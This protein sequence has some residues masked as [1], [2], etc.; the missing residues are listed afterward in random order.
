[1]QKYDKLSEN[2]EIMTNT[3][4]I[5]QIS[6]FFSL[7]R[8]FTLVNSNPFWINGGIPWEQ[9]QDKPAEDL[10]SF[11]GFNQPGHLKCGR[12]FMLA[13]ILPFRLQTIIVLNGSL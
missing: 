3:S 5:T 10:V 2:S 13:L 8:F 7:S 6:H 4:R 9:W 11:H 1:M 12:T